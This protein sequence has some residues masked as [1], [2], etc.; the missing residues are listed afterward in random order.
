MKGIEYY[1]KGMTPYH[2]G[3]YNPN[4]LS[5]WLDDCSNGVEEVTF[6]PF[7]RE[8]HEPFTI[9]FALISME[10]WILLCK[11]C[12]YN[13]VKDRYCDMGKVYP[14]MWVNKEQLDGLHIPNADPSF[15]RATEDSM[16]QHRYTSQCDDAMTTSC[17]LYFYKIEDEQDTYGVIEHE[18]YM[19]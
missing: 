12:E 13:N 19:N 15:E 17:A 2:D 10:D 3:A 4:P 18:Y 16:K 9:S 6:H 8:G 7:L 14:S 1:K 5:D 11:L